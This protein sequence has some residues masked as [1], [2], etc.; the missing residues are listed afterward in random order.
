MW[1]IEDAI[2]A[3]RSAVEPLGAESLALTEAVGRVLAHAVHA[4]TAH[5]HANLS[6]MDG[7]AVCS[8]HIP[9]DRRFDLSMAIPAGTIPVESLTPGQAA[10]I[11]TGAQL[12]TGADCVVPQEEATREDSAVV[13]HGDMTAGRF[14]RSHAADLTPG[15]PLAAPGT[16][17]TPGLL[18]VLVAQSIARVDVVRRP[19]VSIVPN[20][21][22]LV[23]FGT[24]P[25][26]GKIVDV[27]G[28]LLEAL[29]TQ[30]GAQARRYDPI[31]DDRAALAHRLEE[32]AQG[33]DLVLVTGGMSVGDHD[34]ARDLLGHDE[35]A[36]FYRVA[37]RPGKPLGLGRVHGVPMLGMPGNP[38]STF[39]S[40]LRF[41]RP[42]LRAM[43]GTGEPARQTA[44]LAAPV[45][46]LKTRTDHL[47]ATIDWRDGE[48]WVVPAS[49]QGSGDLSGLLQS[50]ALI[51]VPTGDTELRAGTTVEIIPCQ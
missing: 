5:P 27:N 35:P 33:A 37:S 4:T 24:A 30:N 25:P 2:T 40:F 8:A 43:R 15:Q 50:D 29:L 31:T 12:P 51:V 11:Y 9:A 49:R 1:T 19:V 42:M 23:P 7:Y 44:R 34:H 32:A 48:A 14:V 10:R 26:P 3:C 41:A 21:A 45:R 36:T 22:E 13:L 47:R 20:G 6:A 38:V 17:L 46:P 28:P 18:A 39:V 16:R